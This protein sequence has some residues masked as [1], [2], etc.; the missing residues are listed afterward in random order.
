MLTVFGSKFLGLEVV[1]V[2]NGDQHIVV[3]TWAGVRDSA[4]LGG[5]SG[6]SKCTCNPLKSIQQPLLNVIPIM[7]KSP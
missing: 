6:L 3:P 2:S 5:S 1:I 7:N 4:L